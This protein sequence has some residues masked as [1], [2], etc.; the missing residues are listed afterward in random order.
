VQSGLFGLLSFL[1]LIGGA[2]FS[3][4]RSYQKRALNHFEMILFISF[5]A[6]YIVQN[7]TVFDTITSFLLFTVVL[8]WIAHSANQT[9]A[10]PS[11]LHHWSLL[12][13]LSTCIL[14]VT[15]F[16]FVLQPMRANLSTF[17]V[18]FEPQMDTR[19]LLYEQAVKL[20]PSGVD[21]RRSF[22]AAQ[23]ATTIL[24]QTDEVRKQG[25]SFFERELAFSRD[26]LLS[27]ISHTPNFLRGYLDLGF[28]DL[29]WG[30]YYDRRKYLEAEQI[31]QAA[32]IQN[33]RN[34]WSY[35]GLVMVYLDQGKISEALNLAEDALRLDPQVQDS[36]T[37]R[38]IA[39]LFSGD[40]VLTTQKMEESLV[41]FP[42]LRSKF[43]EY[44]RYNP[45][46][47][48]EKS[49]LIFRFYYDAKL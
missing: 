14:P 7:L 30:K 46:I 6:A 1:L 4:W 5:F 3:L 22:L 47:E 49:F 15:L 24:D 18:K 17:G 33:P 42:N 12:P 38:L 20:S 21:L 37:R 28:I 40:K 34:Q 31:L 44:K 2:C 36:H 41:L 45:Q 39:Y 48:S 16:F 25:H 43:D 11:T 27:S 13:V 9:S 8:A 19:L 10:K 29:T 35:W 23:T 26:A 32:L